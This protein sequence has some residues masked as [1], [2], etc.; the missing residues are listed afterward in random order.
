[1]ATKAT[2]R[3]KEQN[4]L[5]NMVNAIWKQFP[6]LRLYQL[7]DNAGICY[8]DSDEAAYGKLKNYVIQQRR[9]PE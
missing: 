7:F 8:Y 9:N 3:E 4:K 2:E 1:M 5:I 6:H